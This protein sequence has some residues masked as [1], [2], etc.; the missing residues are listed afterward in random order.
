M[1]S[2]WMHIC[3]M[4]LLSWWIVEADDEDGVEADEEGMSWSE[5][6]GLLLESLLDIDRS[7]EGLSNYRKKK[8]CYFFY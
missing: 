5:F 1:P 3:Q 4:L 2:S 7:L 8:I 6:A